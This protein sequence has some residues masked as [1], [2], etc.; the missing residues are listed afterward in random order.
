[1]K[2][3]FVKNSWF[4]GFMIFQILPFGVILFY[5][6]GFNSR[7]GDA[8]WMNDSQEGCKVFTNF[9]VQNRRAEWSGAC[10]EGYAHGKGELKVF[11]GSRV[12]YIFEGILSKGKMEGEGSL[13]FVDD[14][15]VYEGKFEES[16]FH[17]YGHYFNDDGDH[18][19]GFYQYGKKSG[20]GTYWYEPT[21]A[22]F[23]YEGEWK[24]GLENGNGTLFYKDGQL[25][26]GVFKN[27][28]LLLEQ[29]DSILKPKNN[30]KHILITNDDGVEDF[31][32]LICLAEPVSKFADLVVIAVS[33]ENKSGTSN[34]TSVFKNGSI[35][36]ERIYSDSIRQI[37]AYEVEG[38]PADCVI[39]GALG[40]F[41]EQEKTID[42][43]I[44]GINGG[45][46]IGVEWFGSGTIGAA[47]MSAIAKIPAIAVSGIDGEYE[48]KDKLEQICHWVAKLAQSKIVDKIRPLEYLTISLPKNLDNVK[49]IKVLERAITF[50]Q[51]PFYLEKEEN[52]YTAK[53]HK[54]R[55]RLLPND[56]KKSYKFPSE[57]DVY[58][59]LQNYIVIVPMSVDEN[60]KENITSYKVLEESLPKLK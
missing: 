2:N 8:G 17:G 25:K 13:R 53:Q 45:P 10:K 35:E 32:R 6:L 31:D 12:L 34:S 59:H 46:N 54:I 27:G 29:E 20:W 49:G 15:D 41:R 58:Y 50:D 48:E 22:I 16:L 26:S 1:M 4:A 55:W 47:R 28:K 33:R 30:P 43:V 19:E 5:L 52:T 40:I 42:L 9:N 38:Y 7:T 44:S 51:S 23:K 14:G 56:P 21:S 60:I 57:T 3:N 18:F 24:N 37:Y 11:E 36:A 39:L